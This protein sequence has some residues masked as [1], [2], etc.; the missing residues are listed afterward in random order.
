M[1][2]RKFSLSSLSF[3]L[4]LLIFAVVVLLTTRPPLPFVRWS[5]PVFDWLAVKPSETSLPNVIQ[6]VVTQEEAVEKVVE[7]ASPAVVSVVTRQVYLDIFRGPVSE[8]SAIGTGFVVD[9]RGLILTNKHVVE[10][11]NATYTVVLPDEKAY[12]VKTIARDPLNDLAI[13][14][15]EAAV[16]PVLVLGDSAKVRVGQS[17][18]AIGN[19]LGRFSNTVTTGVISGIGRGITAGSGFGAS[20]TL[21]DVFQTD[22]ALNPGNSGGPLLNLAGEVIGINVAISQTGENIGFAIPINLAQRTLEGYQKTGRISQPFLGVSYQ[23]V[24]E[25]LA[26]MRRLPVGAFVERVVSGSGA[27]KAGLESG[28]IITKIDGVSLDKRRPLSKI[29]RQHQVGDTLTLTVD[30]SGKELTLRV[31]LGESA[32]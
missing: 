19:A 30:R 11:E 18:V 26:K 22:A 28:D 8:E 25:D 1:I 15:I 12:E 16:L 20:E 6:K 29:I 9:G 24:T 31:T 17:V 10:N 5:W 32:P 21:E 14:K 13:L 27:E 3:W 7:K 4:A 23:M 2:G